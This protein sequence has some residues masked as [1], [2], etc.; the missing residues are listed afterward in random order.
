MKPEI[1]TI[2]FLEYGVKGYGFALMIGFLT[3]IAWAAHRADKV[4]SNPDLVI[5]MGFVALVFG[6]LGARAF[7]V[8][9]YWER[10]FAGRPL[11][12]AINLTAGGLE[13]YGGFLGAMVFA[14]LYILSH[15]RPV[16]TRALAGFW[17][18]TGLLVLV[19]INQALG[20]KGVGAVVLA[21]LS[22]VFAF[23]I[24]R[25]LWRWAADA[26]RANPVSLRLYLDIVTPSLMW[27]LAFGRIGCFLNGCCWGGPCTNPHLPWAV[28]FPYAS[29]AHYEQWRDGLVTLPAELINIDPQ[30]GAAE[31]IH[32]DIIAAA[33]HGLDRY[34]GGVAKAEKKIESMKE[35]GASDSSLKG[36]E[37]SLACQQSMRN[38][39]VKG[40][41]P[42]TRNM[43]LY[44]LTSDQ[45]LAEAHRESSETI[46]VQPAQLYACVNAFLLAFLLNAVFYRRKRHGIVFGL[47]WLLYPITRII[48]ETIRIDNPLDTAGLTVSQGISV[49]GI[50]LA[51]VWFYA[52]YRLPVRS[53]VAVPYVPPEPPPPRRKQ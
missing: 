7:Y 43:K 38:Q 23:Y 32:R 5:N 11:W 15:G 37:R 24:V 44:G 22:C 40:V 10:T 35:S 50:A 34:A 3:A 21:L 49:V 52:M 6:V 4:K 48:L 9:H 27:G 1:F 19:M 8:I 33:A 31:P 16:M 51:G 41:E 28:R 12:E 42:F 30:T 18:L 39:F 26:G 53:P 36:A 45:L 46:P 17:S 14:I 2:P 29:P 13:F 20:A 25:A 47:M